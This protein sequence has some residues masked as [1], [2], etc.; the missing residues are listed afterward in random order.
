MENENM[1]VIVSKRMMKEGLLRCLKKKS[2]DKIT[3]TELCREAQVNRATFYNHY[4]TPFQILLEIGWDHANE[5][6]NIFGTNIRHTDESVR[7]RM[8]NCFEYLYEN[9]ASVKILF[10]ANADKFIAQTS[11]EIF[12]WSWQQNLDLKKHIELND[13]EYKLAVNSYGWAAYHLI[14]QWLM[15][16]I[17]L[18]PEE[19]TDLF[20]KLAGKNIFG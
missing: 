15:E 3:I 7:R 5:I 1:R 11:K 2:I 18:S 20:I 17:E 19:I 10:S 16:D 6:K 4:E 13:N 14:K 12:S 9:K 8:T